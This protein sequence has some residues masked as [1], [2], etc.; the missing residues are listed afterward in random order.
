MGQRKTQTHEH[1]SEQIIW[2]QLMLT[3]KLTLLLSEPSCEGYSQNTES[4]LKTL[5]SSQVLQ[6]HAGTLLL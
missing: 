6:V 1:T 5:H 2:V 4:F 3:W